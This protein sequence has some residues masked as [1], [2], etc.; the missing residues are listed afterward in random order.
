MANIAIP[1]T[2]VAQLESRSISGSDTA[3]IKALRNLG[4]TRDDALLAIKGKPE[5]QAIAKAKYPAIILP[6][7]S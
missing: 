7:A 3:A 5:A 4:Y 6:V 2:V 1:Y